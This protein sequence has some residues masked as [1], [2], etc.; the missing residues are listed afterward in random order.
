MMSMDVNEIV[1]RYLYG[2][3]TPPSNKVDDNTRE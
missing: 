1:S 2:S 3:A